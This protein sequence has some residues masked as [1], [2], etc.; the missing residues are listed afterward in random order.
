MRCVA[1]LIP[2]YNEQDTIAAALADLPRTLPGVD[3]VQL[4]VVD[5]GSLDGT[6]TAARAANCSHVIQLAAHA[7]LGAA[8]KEGLRYA[9]AEINPD[10]IVNFD[11]DLQYFGD[12]I[13][14]LIDP[15]RAGC[16]DVVIGDRRVHR[17]KGYPKY[18]IFTQHFWNL[19]VSISVRRRIKDATSGFRAYSRDTAR[20]LQAHLSE[21]YTYSAESLF[22]LAKHRARIAFVPISTRTTHRPS[23]LITSKLY[24]TRYVFALLFRHVVGEFSGHFRTKPR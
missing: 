7:G 3:T 6:V 5:D 24:Y 18:K 12:D 11:A 14:R 21:S 8:H 19:V 20:W 22:L 15:I 10:I 4:I 1:I 16:A 9:L 23:R 17:I 2:A 13:A